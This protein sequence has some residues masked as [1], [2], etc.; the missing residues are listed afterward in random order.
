V[1]RQL[2]AIPGT[3]VDDLSETGRNRGSIRGQGQAAEPEVLD[4]VGA[5]LGPVSLR[6]PAV[7]AEVLTIGCIKQGQFHGYLLYLLCAMQENAYSPHLW[8]T[9]CIG[10]NYS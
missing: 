7:L 9:I 1:G 5:E 8:N 4:P 6:I 3:P 10:A 2:L